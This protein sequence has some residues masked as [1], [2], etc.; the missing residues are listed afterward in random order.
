MLLAKGDI[1]D[2]IRSFM[3]IFPKGEVADKIKVG[4]ESRGL[5][6]SMGFLV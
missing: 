1:A 3:T 4:A 6:I 2:L 5:Q